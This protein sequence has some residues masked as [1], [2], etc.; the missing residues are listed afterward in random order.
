[1]PITIIEM[2]TLTDTRKLESSLTGGEM[3]M[4]V[5]KMLT[6]QQQIELY[7]LVQRYRFNIWDSA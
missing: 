7:T 4:K 6:Q 5:E 2:I 1:M 3:A